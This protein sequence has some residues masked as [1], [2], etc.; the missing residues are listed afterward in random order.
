MMD[1]KKFRP[2]ARGSKDFLREE[3]KRKVDLTNM[4]WLIASD[5]HGSA[6]YC[7]QLLEAYQREG[8]DRLLLLGDLLY[9]GPRNGLPEGY[10]PKAVLEMLNARKQDILSVRGNCD[11]EVD[12]MV[13]AFPILADYCLLDLGDRMIFATHG[14]HYNESNLPPLHQGDV[15][16]H[17]HTHVPVCASRGTYLYCNPG[18]VSLPK[19]NSYRGYMTLQ[20]RRLTWRDLEGN[21]QQ[22]FQL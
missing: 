2:P 3:T 17:G 16:L 11:A 15:L 22:E 19:E 18:S 4:K 21:L 9:H 20:N 7:A 13:L 8:A 6:V 1:K 14:H 10:D 5:I 12:Q